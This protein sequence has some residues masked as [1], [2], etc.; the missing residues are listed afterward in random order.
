MIQ[1]EKSQL[2]KSNADINYAR[3]MLHDIWNDIYDGHIGVAIAKAQRADR[4][5]RNASNGIDNV[6][7]GDV[8][9]WFY[10]PYRR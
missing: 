10:N 8:K 5:L 6:L 1:A 9:K 2:S 7:N 4:V 3:E